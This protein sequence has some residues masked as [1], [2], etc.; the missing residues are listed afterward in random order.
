ML[1]REALDNLLQLLTGD[2]EI[3]HAYGLMFENLHPCD[4]KL[5]RESMEAAE[6]SLEE[7]KPYFCRATYEMYDIE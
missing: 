1:P 4:K 2:D 6:A 7:D 3:C 5:L